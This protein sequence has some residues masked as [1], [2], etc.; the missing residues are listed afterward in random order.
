MLARYHQVKF[1][2]TEYKATCPT[3]SIC[4]YVFIV[5]RSKENCT[6]WRIV[7]IWYSES[8]LLID[9]FHYRVPQAVLGNGQGIALCFSH[10]SHF[11]SRVL[12]RENATLFRDTN[13]VLFLNM[14]IVD[15][16][17]A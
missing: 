16:I 3:H 7:G 5:H 4:I 6:E 9:A 10:L 12:V 17:P 1:G 15:D 8:N 2:H 11:A 13:D 14:K